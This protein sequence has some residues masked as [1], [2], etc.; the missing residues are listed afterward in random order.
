MEVQTFRYDRKAQWSIKS[1]P[2]I[3]SPRTLV[4]VFGASSF[5]DSVGP[6]AELIDE[7]PQSTVVGC[8]TAG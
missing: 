8:S 5:A 2:R 4:V 3:D 1:R 6:L 7:Y